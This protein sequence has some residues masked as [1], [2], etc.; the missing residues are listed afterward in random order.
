MPPGGKGTKTGK[1]WES[2]IKPVLE[3]HYA[4]RF[5][6]QVMVGTQLF[7]GA[8]VADLVISDLERGDLIVSA[9]WQQV[10][11][12]AEQKVIYDIASLLS[13]IRNQGE[14]FRKAY[15]VLG[16]PGFSRNAREFL[17]G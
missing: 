10:P 17:L 3:I 1:Y 7:G 12:T 14:R 8:Y 5:Q 11:G 15:I 16:G 13:I 9:K 2:V 4:D 6:T